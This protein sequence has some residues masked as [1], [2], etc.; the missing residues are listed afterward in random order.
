MKELNPTDAKLIQD[1]EAEL[2]YAHTVQDMFPPDASHDREIREPILPIVPNAETISLA[3]V[4]DLLAYHKK[5]REIAQ[6]R[7]EHGIFA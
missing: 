4:F 5:Q 6:Y 3:A 1:F 2:A 7:A